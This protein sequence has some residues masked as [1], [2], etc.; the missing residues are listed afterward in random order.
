VRHLALL[1]RG[2]T[3]AII[4]IWAL[5]SGPGGNTRKNT[6]PLVEHSAGTRVADVG[7]GS[8]SHPF[9]NVLVIS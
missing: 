2:T 6:C 9:S 7:G 3:A 8:R 5:L 1:M 4:A